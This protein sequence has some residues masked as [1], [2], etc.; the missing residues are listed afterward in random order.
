VL[1]RLGVSRPAERSPL[2]LVV[3]HGLTEWNSQQRWQGMADIALSEGGE[4]QAAEAAIALA[5]LTTST[6]VAFGRVIAS[7]LIRAARTADVL[8]A[9]I[10]PRV[11]VEFDQRWRERDVGPWSGLTTDKIE[12]TWP[13]EL[14]RW[15]DGH[16]SGV[17]GVE[18][19]H[20]FE[21]RLGEALH[22]SLELA[23]AI[24][25]QVLVVAHGGVLR[26][27]D[28]V[29]GSDPAAVPNLSGRWFGLDRHG[30]ARGRNRIHLLDGHHS[31]G[32]AL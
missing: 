6:G 32:T 14:D 24:G 23:V 7:D 29:V 30:Q 3:R 17:D 12:A 19:H 11:A 31:V 25:Q 20:M 10:L 28:R 4:R 5:A 22:A 1:Y 13:G 16:D 18:P 9:A 8:A 15:R 21:K 2:V 27:L 26:G